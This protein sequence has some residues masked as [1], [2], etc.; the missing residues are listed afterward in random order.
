MLSFAR[1]SSQVETDVRDAPIKRSG[2]Q[3]VLVTGGA[4][5]I[6][7]E[8]C[9]AFAR[10]S[11]R[12]GLIDRDQTK[13]QTLAG[14]PRQSGVPCASTY[15]RRAGSFAEGSAALHPPALPRSAQPDK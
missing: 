7:R 11:A 3:V 15:F 1:R 5:G 2:E 14:I 4:S 12:I 13:L 9:L 10:N 8:L 6:G